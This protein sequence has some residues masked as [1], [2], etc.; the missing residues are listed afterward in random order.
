MTP[1]YKITGSPSKYELSVAFFDFLPG[2]HRRP[3]KFKV[4]NIMTTDHTEIEVVIN[5]IQWEDGSANSWAFEG[6]VI[7]PP[8]GFPKDVKGW[9]RTTNRQGYID[10]CE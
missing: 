1:K 5:S 3:V 8:E 10:S 9:F 7:N 2:N 6:Y 4:E